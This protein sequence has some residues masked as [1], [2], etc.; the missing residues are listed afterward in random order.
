MPGAV[1]RNVRLSAVSMVSTNTIGGVGVG[2]IAADNQEHIL[3]SSVSSGTLSSEDGYA[4]GLV[5]GNQ[6]F[7]EGCFAGETVGGNSAGGLAAQNLGVIEN[8]YSTGSVTGAGNPGGL[9]AYNGQTSVIENSHATGAVTGVGSGGLVGAN[10]GWIYSSYATGSAAGGGL[11]GLADGGMIEN[12]YATGVV[13]PSSVVGGLIG[14]A[15]SGTVTS[16]YATGT[17]AVGHGSSA[18]GFVGIDET[19]GG[20]TNAFWDTTTSGRNNGTGNR[21]NEFGITGL[22]TAQFQSGLPSGFDPKIWG[23][24]ANINGGL[25]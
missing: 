22:T 9:V 19:A 1:L 3:S 20:I 16:S 17:I 2:A 11:V 8:S 5:A 18:G 7:I 23:E 14:T 6:G 13:G 21:G 10:Q 25:P 24:S 12:T 4:G 15:Q